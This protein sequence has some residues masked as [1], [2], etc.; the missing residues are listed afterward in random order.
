[1]AKGRQLWCKKS[2]TRKPGNV[3][4]VE[5]ETEESALVNIA[6]HRRKAAGTA[7][8]SSEDFRKAADSQTGS[9]DLG[10]GIPP[11]VS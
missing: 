4:A 8:S 6:A 11:F 10:S 9:K 5:D 1:M 7:S 2:L 3:P